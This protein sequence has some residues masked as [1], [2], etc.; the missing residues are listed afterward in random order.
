M[1]L[2]PFYEQGPIF[3]AYN[4]LTDATHPTNLTIAGISL[5]VLLCPSDPAMATKPSL[6][7][8]YT[9]P[10]GAWYQAQT[11]YSPVWTCNNAVAPPGETG[12]IQG[13]AST[14]LASVTD[15]TS[16]TALFC[17]AAQG[18]VSASDFAAGHVEYRPWNTTG[19]TW[20]DFQF[21]P[22]PRRYTPSNKEFDYDQPASMHP[23]GL[24]VCFTDGSVHFIKDS[25]SSWPNT[26]PGYGIPA[27]YATYTVAIVSMSPFIASETASWTAAAKLGVWQMLATRNGGEVISSDSY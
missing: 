22:N 6:T 14:P 20:I 17:E 19:D 13:G 9:L 10:P 2:L 24:N 27:N 5:N 3:N 23:G 25:V 26:A 4:C 21:A 15:G 7:A 16:N 18:W 1:R 12:V 8:Q 11:N